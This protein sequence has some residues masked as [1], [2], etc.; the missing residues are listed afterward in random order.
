MQL[1][2]LEVQAE[3]GVR[4]WAPAEEPLSAPRLRFVRK[5][6]LCPRRLW[7]R[8]LYLRQL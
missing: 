7:R 4:G 3:V 5:P 8:P 1:L 6:L 2:A